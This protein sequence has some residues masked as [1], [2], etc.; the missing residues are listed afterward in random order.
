MSDT[1]TSS[2]WLSLVDM[3]VVFAVLAF[4]MLVSYSLKLFSRGS[5]EGDAGSSDDGAGDVDVASGDEPAHEAP[6]A[7]HAPVPGQDAE[8]LAAVAS[9]VD[10]GATG[11]DGA[12]VVPVRG[13]SSPAHT[14]G[15]P[16][17]ITI[18]WRKPVDEHSSNPS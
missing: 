12:P 3:L 15:T 8:E 5:V 9:V 6:P 2:L 1:M 16:T 11:T 7:W 14:N 17:I 4:L 13:L 10:L 18:T